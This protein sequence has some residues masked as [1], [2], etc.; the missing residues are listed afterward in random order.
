MNRRVFLGSVAVVVAFTATPLVRRLFSPVPLV[1]SNA[2]G[3]WYNRPAAVGLD[4]GFCFGYITSEGDVKVA[5]ITSDLLLRRTIVL[6]K[7]KDASDHGSPSLIKI[8]VGK[9]RDKILACFSN[10]ASPL[11]VMKTIEPLD[12]GRWEKPR[13]LDSGRATYTSLAILP[14]GRIVLMYTLQERIGLYSTGEWRRTVVRVSAD[15]GEVWSE[16]IRIAGF[17]A[18][19]FPYSTPI[20]VSD[21][22]V[23]AVA[24][25]VY[26]SERKRHEGLRVLVSS[27]AFQSKYEVPIDLGENVVLDTVPYEVKWV[28]EDTVAV[29]YTQMD[30]DNKVGLSKVAFVKVSGTVATEIINLSETAVHTYPGGAALNA[31]GS[32]AFSS[33]LAGGLI[34]HDLQ[35]LQVTV[36]KVKGEFS[37]PYV[38]DLDGKSVLL[39]LRNPLI[40]S[41]RDFFAETYIMPLS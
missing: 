32:A 30:L 28:D 5:E 36:L 12:V 34:K 27:D 25:A 41:T 10:H 31:T 38:F 3:L 4:G 2:Y 40:K 37:A 35:T 22:G 14:D 39:A 16:P 33:P 15:G 1:V 20:N 19:T 29:S 6:H 17:G 18:G 23:C 24:Y 9:H 26:S 11:M 8:P 21:K 7:F 13:V